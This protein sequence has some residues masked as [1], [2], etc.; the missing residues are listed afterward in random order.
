MNMPAS[1]W[2]GLAL[3]IAVFAT[4]ELLA[5]KRLGAHAHKQWREAGL[6]RLAKS[7]AWWEKFTIGASIV[8]YA[9]A[10]ILGLIGLL[11]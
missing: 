10:L 1:S 8:L 11:S 6:E 2:F 7:R 9:V 3:S 4:I 5:R